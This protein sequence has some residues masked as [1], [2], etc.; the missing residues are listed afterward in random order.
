MRR[1]ESVGFLHVGF[2]IGA[3]LLGAG[4]YLLAPPGSYEGYAPPHWR[5]GFGYASAGAIAHARFFGEITGL[6]PGTGVT[7][8]VPPL[9][10]AAFV[11]TTVMFVAELEAGGSGDL[12][13]AVA[14]TFGKE[15]YLSGV[16]DPS[17]QYISDFS[18]DLSFSLARHRDSAFGG[19]LTYTAW[20]LGVRLAGPRRYVPRYYLTG[21]WGWYGFQYDSPARANAAIGGPYW[22]FGL[23]MF[24]GPR[25]AL[26]V[27]YKM[28]F[29][30]G[31]DEAGVP[32]DGGVMQLAAF[33][34]AY[35]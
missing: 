27:E 10:P 25:L 3:A 2:L 21:G 7:F 4:C 12:T 29:Y 16:S 19:S 32:V 18:I 1:A 14:G 35:W 6:E 26:G 5:G 30:F 34:S 8:T 11:L 28:H 23:E 17:K 33:V 24:P 31:S 15:A 9:A 13:G 20:L 22:G